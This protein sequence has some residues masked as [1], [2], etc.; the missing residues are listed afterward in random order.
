VSSNLS[1]TLST[2][3]IALLVAIAMLTTSCK[4]K[5]N[6]SAG[7]VATAAAVDQT[8]TE[9]GPPVPSGDLHA[10]V[11]HFAIAVFFTP[12]PSSKVDAEA[13]VRRTVQGKGIAV[14]TSL[15]D[16]PTDDL[17]V[18]VQH[19]SLTEYP[20]PSA[21][22]LQY[23]ARGLSDAEE[24]SLL[25]AK[26]VT[27]LLFSGPPG[28]AVSTYRLAVEIGA[29]LAKATGGLIYDDETRLSYD[30]TSWRATVDEWEPEVPNVAQNTIIHMYRDGELFRLVTLG[31]AKFALPDIS[32]NQVSSHDASP[33]GTLINLACQTLVERGTID[34][35]GAL[36]VRIGSIRNAKARSK[37]G[38]DLARG[39]TKKA[40]LHVALAEAREGDADNRLMEI[41]FFGPAGK[42]QEEHNATLSTLFGSQDDVVGVKADDREIQAASARAKVAVMKYKPVFRRGAPELERLTVKGPF[43]TSN[44]GVEW[45]WVEVLRWEGKTIHGV[46]QNDPYDVPELKAG[47]R[48]DVS[49]DSIF[50]YIYRGADGGVEGNETSALIEA[51]QNQR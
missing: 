3:G 42:L 20:P 18:T 33:M 21:E 38:E 19:P 11:F 14:H 15:P 51:R 1:R 10:R 32:V 23:F 6:P 36:A 28:A 47:A 8:S 29:A 41:V 44:D 48:V 27:V 16:P 7:P 5:S 17:Q 43:K 46:L 25:D 26:A 31:M 24:R 22:N 13:L 35:P 34:Q 4:R 12:G 50:D 2:S 39:A 49:E 37:F 45:M 40:S 30:E 9:A